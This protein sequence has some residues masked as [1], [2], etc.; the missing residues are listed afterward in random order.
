MQWRRITR[1]RPCP[2]CGKPDWCGVSIDECVAVCMR[3][4]SD[5][6][7]RNGGWV[8]RLRDS[9]DWQ[10]SQLHRASIPLKSTPDFGE[11]ARKCEQHAHM[12]Q[13]ERLASSLGVSVESLRRLGVGWD[14]SAWTFPVQNGA[15]SVCGIRRRHL[16][17]GKTFVLGSKA[18]LF[19]PSG[20]PAGA[21]VLITEG[22]SDCAA[23]LTFGFQSVGRCGCRGGAALLSDYCR[24]RDVAILGDTDGPGRRGARALAQVLAIVCQSVRN[25]VPPDGTKDLRHWLQRGGTRADVQQLIRAADPVRVGV[26][27]V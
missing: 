10:R 18:G 8:H 2:V 9:G 22:E 16:D 12:Q 7:S 1:G 26:C 23:A 3:I 13:V 4:E 25:V 20:I 11:L 15:G 14:C 21:P 6:P 24:G 5:K 27:A 19:V 17:G